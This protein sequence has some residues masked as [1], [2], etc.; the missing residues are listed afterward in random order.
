[1][2]TGKYAE[3]TG[4]TK[5]ADKSAQEMLTVQLRKQSLPKEVHS[6]GHH[7]GVTKGGVG[8]PAATKLG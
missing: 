8:L 6:L 2:A 3:G 7:H 1:M 4:N 5:A